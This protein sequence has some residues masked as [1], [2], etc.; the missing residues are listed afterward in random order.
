MTNPIFILLL[1]TVNFFTHS[2]LLAYNTIENDGLAERVKS[3]PDISEITAYPDLFFECHIAEMSRNTSIKLFYNTTVRH[4][5]NLYFT[6]RIDQ[7]SIINDRSRVY[8]PVI[9]KYLEKFN[10]PSELKFLAILESALSETA[11]SPSG[12]VGLWQ[13][14]EETGISCGLQIDKQNDERTNPEA[15]TIAACKYLK[16]MY[17][18]FGDWNLAVMAYQ[19]G[20]GTIRRAIE[21]SGGRTTYFELLPFLPEQTVKYLPA[22]FSIMYVFTYYGNHL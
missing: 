3:E 15:S 21:S 20:P 13:F 14:K 1:L 16:E 9:S 4:Y 18:M 12:A 5:I 8:F 17:V 7:I 10:L 22:F 11:V 2:E 6:E 19:A